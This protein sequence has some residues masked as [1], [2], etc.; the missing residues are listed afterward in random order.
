MP[1]AAQLDWNDVS[2]FLA[3]ARHRNLSETARFLRV[4]HTTVGR[5]IRALEDQLNQRLFERSRLG[6]LLTDAG[7]TLLRHAEGMEEHAH[8]IALEF[9]T[10]SEAPG[11][12]VRVATMEALGSLYLAPN[13]ADLYRQK[14]A[15]RIE[16][17][18]ASHWINLSKREADILISFPKPQGRRITVNKIG[19]F[20]L[21]LYATPGYLKKRGIPE[22]IDDLKNHRLIDYIDE[23][24]Q[25]SA[26]RWLSD[27]IHE[28]PADFRSTSLVAQYHATAAG[29]GISMLPTFVAARDKRLVRV[30]DDTVVVKRDFWLAVHEDLLHLVRV[31][32]VMSYLTTLIENDRKFLLGKS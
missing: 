8:S 11:G 20:A 29:L 30:L 31:R 9:A 21:H 19:E 25:I 2:V 5:R 12:V 23:L 7:H 28:P 16:L 26:V 17:V 27:M 6:F 4:N 32:E 18:T 1:E 13:M 22:T 24:V 14:P 15:V 3:L 10:S